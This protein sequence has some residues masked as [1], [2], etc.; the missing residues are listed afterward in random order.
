MNKENWRVAGC[1]IKV[2]TLTVC[3][4]LM[5]GCTK[6][7]KTSEVCDLSLNLNAPELSERNVAINGGLTA[8]VKRIQW[9]WGDGTV[10]KHRYFPARHTY[11]APGQYAVKVTAYSIKGCS[12]EKSVT[13]TIK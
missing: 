10:D 3:A 12:E 8:P 4:L 1:F 2:L 5:F 6:E 11:S 13:V 7:P 9:D